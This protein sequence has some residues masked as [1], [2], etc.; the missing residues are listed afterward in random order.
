MGLLTGVRF[1][2]GRDLPSQVPPLTP[3]TNQ[4][5]TQALAASFSSWEKERDLYNILRDPR[6]W[7]EM[8]VTRWLDWAIREF[9]LEGVNA[10]NFR[11]KGKDI[12]SLG[13]DVFLSLAPPYVGEILWEHLDRLQRDVDVG[14]TGGNLESI[15]SNMY[16]A[17]CMPDLDEFFQHDPCY[18]PLREQKVT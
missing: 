17:V 16:E 15:P 7:N 5:M 9:N 10:H 13:K 4:K 2:P 8:D 6:L 3:G 11:M 1:Y 12:C 14:R 18:A